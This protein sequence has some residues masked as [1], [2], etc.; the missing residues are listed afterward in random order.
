MRA[1]VLKPDEEEVGKF[2]QS[3]AVLFWPLVKVGAVLLAAGWY[4]WRFDLWDLFGTVYSILAILLAVYYAHSLVLWYLDIYRVTTQRFIKSSYRTIFH[5]QV[6]ETALDR[7]L[8][9]S[10]KSTGPWSVLMNYGDVELQVVGKMEP[11]VVKNVKNPGMIKE[12]L[13][14]LHE[15]TGTK[16]GANTL[17]LSQKGILPGN[18]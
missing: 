6:S 7:I 5:Q 10:F 15:Q 16:L 4:V 18:K 13:L 1:F 3:P 2:R 12:Y 14:R 9:I 11:I 8:N 17:N